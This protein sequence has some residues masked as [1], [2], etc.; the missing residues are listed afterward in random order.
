MEVR[1]ERFV[2]ENAAGD[3]IR[4]DVRRAGTG[5][6]DA[7][8][9]ICHGF[10]G[11]KDWGFFPYVAEQL[12]ARTGYPAISFNFSGSGIGD[13]LLN[14]TELDRFEANTFSKELADLQ[15][16][17]DA[18][19][20]GEL[21]SLEPCGRFGLLGH[22]RGGIATII[23]GAED[24][25]VGGIVTWNAVGYIDRWSEEKKEEWRREGRIEILNAR[26]GQMMPLG[27]GTLEDYERNRERLDLQKAAGR[28]EVP[29]LIVHGT[30]DESVSIEDGELLAEAAPS[31]TTRFLKVEGAGHTFGAVHPFRGTTDEL[32]RAIEESAGWFA[33]HLPRQR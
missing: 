27:I 21:P 30:A 18:A 14:F 3:P 2:L 31:A 33:E 8:I 10:K 5:R 1:H 24:G 22:S 29:Y 15:V 16:V 28:L 25:R 13:D 32:E 20:S 26:T 19:E 11:F 23:T 7:A 12:S 4:G 17:L 6:A 9:V